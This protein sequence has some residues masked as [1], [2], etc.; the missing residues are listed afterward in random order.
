MLSTQPFEICEKEKSFSVATVLFSSC[1]R[2]MKKKEPVYIKNEA[3]EEKK[4][5]AYIEWLCQDA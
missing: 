4:R 3:L 5:Q 2:R 1:F